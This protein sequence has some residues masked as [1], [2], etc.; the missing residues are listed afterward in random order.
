MH[1]MAELTH[2][3]QVLLDD[4]TH[5]WLRQ[6]SEQTGRSVGDLVRSAVARER[7]EEL[8]RRRTAFKKMMSFGEFEV[9]EDPR[10]LKRQFSKS[11]DERFDRIERDLARHHDR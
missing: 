6:R 9:P 11:L 5:K 1:V 7:D 2:R 3:T 4:S 8:E 10:E